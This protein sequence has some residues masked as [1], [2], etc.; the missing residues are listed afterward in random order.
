M[1][2]RCFWLSNPD[3]V[4]DPE[5]RTSSPDLWVKRVLLGN[6]SQN[7]W[8]FLSTNP[9]CL[10]L[11]GHPLLQ[12]PTLASSLGVALWGHMP[13][14]LHQPMSMSLAPAKMCVVPVEPSTVF[15]LGVGGLCFSSLGWDRRDCLCVWPPQFWLASCKMKIIA[16]HTSSPLAHL[17][18][19]PWKWTCCFWS[20]HAL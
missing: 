1:V 16:S 9:V 10:N 3:K 2:I 20:T 7:T 19:L 6:F 12:T 15:Q 11:G 18:R 5:L 4:W 13:W 14:G 17:S 8:Q